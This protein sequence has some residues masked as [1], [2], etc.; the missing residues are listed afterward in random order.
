M[1]SIR[2]IETLPI[3][4][5]RILYDGRLR[6]PQPGKTDELFHGLS[7]GVG[8]EFVGAPQDFQLPTFPMSRGVAVSRVFLSRWNRL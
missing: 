7:Y 3:S 2:E 8:F 4:L 6:E 1:E 5:Q